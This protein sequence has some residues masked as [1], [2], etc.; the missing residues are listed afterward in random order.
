MVHG[1]GDVEP[2][3][4][5]AQPELLAEAFDALPDPILIT[6]PDGRVIARNARARE[7]LVTS[8][9]DL[10]GRRR[11]VEMNA[12]LLEA[13]LARSRQQPPPT[14]PSAR[15]ATLVDPGDGSD[16]TFE[17]VPQQLGGVDGE[18]GARLVV[19][20]DVTELRHAAR[21]LELQVK[22]VS[23]AEADATRE[24]DR[25]DLVLEHVADP[26]VVTDDRSRVI[27]MNRQAEALFELE[28]GRD[29]APAARQAWAANDAQFLTFLGAFLADEQRMR[30][31]RLSLVRAD[32]GPLPMEIVAGKIA[33][34]HGGPTAVVSVLH[35]LTREVENEQLYE[36]LK[37]SSEQ[38]EARVHAATADLERQNAR[39]QW[40]SRELERANRLKSE[41]LASMS[42]ELR[43]PINALLGY[44]ALLLDRVYGD[45]APQQEQALDR[46]RAA[47]R[48]L[49]ELINDILDLAKIEAGKMPV[50]LEEVPLDALLE[51]VG[52]QVE[53]LLSGKPV[54]FRCH[55]PAERVMLYTDG[56]KVRQILLNLLSN[57]AKF[58]HD[59][60]V[61]LVAQLEPDGERIAFEVRDTGI[62]IQPQDLAAIWEDFRQVDQS[63]TREYG[64]TGLRLSI[65]RKLVQRLDGEVDVRSRFGEGSTFVVRLPLR[66]SPHVVDAFARDALSGGA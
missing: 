41:F 61:E 59:G 31:A 38:L 66:A 9:H 21:E 33:D 27:L 47:A 12:V 14:S 32:G 53:P 56:T 15:E 3:P 1:Q 39:L 5:E 25:L 52:R 55:G 13:A 58:T 22:R 29:A 11:A 6:E 65:T 26:I 57:A 46:M 45:L 62:G 44:A 51:D 43:T 30:H 50:H 20:R 63:R 18:P 17:L 37:R 35:D 49:L 60:S 19:L 7:L 54:V 42:H 16:L 10:E 4:E 28:S 24:R 34:P 64:G 48:H 8:D 23:L 40:Q 2:Q 36:K